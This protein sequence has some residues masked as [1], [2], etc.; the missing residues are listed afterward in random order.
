MTFVKKSGDSKLADGAAK[1]EE[2]RTSGESMTPMERIQSLPS[3]LQGAEEAKRAAGNEAGAQQTAMAMRLLEQTVKLLE[4]MESRVTQLEKPKLEAP[5]P[6]LRCSTCMQVVKNKEGRGVCEGEHVMVVVVPKEM[7]LWSAFPGVTWNGQR[8]AGR[9]MLP[10]SIIDG[11]VS[12][13]SRWTTAQR[14]LHIPGGKIFGDL[15]VRSTAVAPI[16]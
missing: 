7:D 13:I 3:E 6:R 2:V 8:Y 16:I 14:R 15:D 12:E 9:C 4:R 5:A 1:Q 10:P 11:V